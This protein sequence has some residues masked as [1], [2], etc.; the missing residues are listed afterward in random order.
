MRNRNFTN[1]DD[2]GWV[3][4]LFEELLFRLKSRRIFVKIFTCESNGIW[5]RNRL[6]KSQTLYR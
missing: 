6:I 3:K 4:N 2:F 1:R 5:T